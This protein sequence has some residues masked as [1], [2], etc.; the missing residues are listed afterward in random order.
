MNSQIV[1]QFQECAG[2]SEGKGVYSRVTIPK[3]RNGLKCPEYARNCEKKGTLRNVVTILELEI[4]SN[5]AFLRQV[6]EKQNRLQVAIQKIRN[7]LKTPEEKNLGCFVHKSLPHG[8]TL[9]RLN[10]MAERQG[11]RF[12]Q[13]ARRGPC[14]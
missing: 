13:K 6:H 4:A 9:S 11:L 14:D 2:A 3:W 10:Q 12:A 8:T 7:L 1:T 5:Q